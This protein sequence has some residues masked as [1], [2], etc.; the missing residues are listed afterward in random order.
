MRKLISLGLCLLLTGC[1][2]GVKPTKIPK[3]K[4]LPAKSLVITQPRQPTNIVQV[5]PSNKP[6]ANFVVAK[7]PRIIEQA[8]KYAALVTNAQVLKV[9]VTT[10][11]VNTNAPVKIL[12]HPKNRTVITIGYYGLIFSIGSVWLFFGKSKWSKKLRSLLTRNG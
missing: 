3:L 8:P 10:N 6:F 12:P 2:S 5:V 4:P 7:S 1:V 9:P 11:V